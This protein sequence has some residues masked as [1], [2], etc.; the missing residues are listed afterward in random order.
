MLGEHAYAAADYLAGSDDARAEDLNR[1]L[2]DPSI[3]GIFALRGGYGVMRILDRIDYAAFAREPKCVMG[4]SDLT[5][6]LNALNQRC[7]VVTFHGPVASAPMSAAQRECVKRALF[8]GKFEA[9]HAHALVP[10]TASGVLRG[11]NLSLI[12]ALCG[13]PYA[14]DFRDAIAL[15]EDVDEAPYRIDRLLTQLLLAGAF[16]RARGFAIGD[17]P[18]PSVVQERLAALGL[19]VVAGIDAGHLEEQAVLPIGGEAT[20]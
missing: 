6:L 15:I 19:P 18:A 9:P 5:A 10:G 2:R 1:A 17:V 16:E 3:R 8:H 4:Y 7:G 20:I 13:T 11:G 14:I 12:A